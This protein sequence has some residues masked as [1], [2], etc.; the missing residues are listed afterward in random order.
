MVFTVGDPSD[1]AK[2]QEIVNTLL[3]GIQTK[4][5]TFHFVN[6]FA[7]Y[8]PVSRDSKPLGLIVHN[9]RILAG[10]GGSAER[11]ATLSLTTRQPVYPAPVWQSAE[12]ILKVLSRIAVVTLERIS[13]LSFVRAEVDHELLTSL[14]RSYSLIILSLT[15]AGP[16]RPLTKRAH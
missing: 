7:A 9:G 3:D 10:D 11:C 2:I 5:K 8:L 12:P 16:R 13:S 6:D 14:E 1:G 15:S 4:R